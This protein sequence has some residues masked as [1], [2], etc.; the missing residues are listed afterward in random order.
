LNLADK[1]YS[2]S[3]GSSGRRS[4]FSKAAKRA[5]ST[6]SSGGPSKSVV[7]YTVNSSTTA[8]RPAAF[9]GEARARAGEG[10][11]AQLGHVFDEEGGKLEGGLG[12]E[13]VGG[14][15]LEHE[16]PLPGLKEYW[17][18]A[19]RVRPWDGA[20]RRR[21]RASTLRGPAAVAPVSG[22]SSHTSPG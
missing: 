18:A 3:A 7:T 13:D 14:I 5:R 20:V 10:A 8:R 2:I 21:R 22:W 1:V 19:N 4:D 17:L 9:L 12:Q 15:S 16:G 11:V 6:S